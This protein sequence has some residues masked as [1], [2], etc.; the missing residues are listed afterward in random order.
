MRS[1]TAPLVSVVTPVYN[2]A[3]YL[4]QCIDSVLAQ[5]YQNWELTIIDNCSDDESLEVAKQYSQNNSR[6]KVIANQSRLSAFANHNTALRA[7]SPV[8]A[9][10]KVVFADDWIFP[11][12]LEK[13]VALAEENPGVGVV[14]AYWAE[15]DETKG[16]GLPQSVSVLTGRELIRKLLIQDAFL[17]GSANTVLYRASLVRNRDPFFRLDDIHADT[18]VL[19]ELFKKCG[20]G[21]IHETLTYTRAREGSVTDLATDMGSGYAFRLRLL[22][23][24]GNSYLSAAELQEQTTRELRRY[25]R[26]LGK[27][28]LLLRDERFWEY[29]RRELARV[30]SALDVARVRTNA[31]RLVGQGVARPAHFGSRFVRQ[32]RARLACIGAVKSAHLGEL[33]LAKERASDGRH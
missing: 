11:S 25:Y 23:Q 14:S 33:G 4:P 5:T 17:F 10:C 12:C 19:F 2:D 18:E 32:L 31:L 20:F 29:H 3:S 21:F 1:S 22:V 13:M 15:G 8:A 28:L 27:N 7:A 9:Y 26:Y 6:I 24:H 30:G 16:V